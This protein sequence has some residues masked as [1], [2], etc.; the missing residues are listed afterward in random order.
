[1]EWS[2]F[3]Q[4]AGMLVAIIGGSAGV[5]PLVNWLKTQFNL[6]GNIVEVL[7]WIMSAIVAILIAVAGG[8]ITPDLFADPLQLLTVVL[9]VIFGS[10][11][12]YAFDKSKRD[13]QI[14]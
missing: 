3:V 6:E 1:M 5:V 4:F 7:S 12:L 14:N 13:K 2:S 8:V 10:N 9:G 11:K